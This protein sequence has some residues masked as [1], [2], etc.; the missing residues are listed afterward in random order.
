MRLLIA[1]VEPRHLAALRRAL[2]EEGL[3]ATF[4]ASSGGFMRRGNTT[5]FLALPE[6]KV[7]STLALIRKTVGGPTDSPAG[8]VYTHVF[9]VPGVRFRKF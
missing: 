6:E 5:F 8:P 7:E 3:S 4:V 2:A 1:V 9:V